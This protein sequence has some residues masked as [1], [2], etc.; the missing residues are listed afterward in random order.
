MCESAFREDTKDETV[1]I[2]KERNG[3]MDFE[4]LPIGLGVS[5]AMN[6]RAM[7]RFANMTEAEKERTIA[8]SRQVKSKR[9]MDRIVDALAEER[10]R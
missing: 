6:E 2:F 7:E 8:R 10:V 9:E 4:Q 5:L 3:S 1:W